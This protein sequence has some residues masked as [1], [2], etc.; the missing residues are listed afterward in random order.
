MLLP[1]CVHNCFAEGN[2]PNL[3]DKIGYFPVIGSVV[4]VIRVVCGIDKLINALV[5]KII[6]SCTK[7]DA[8]NYFAEMAYLDRNEGLLNVLRGCVEVVPFFGGACTC[9]YDTYYR[10]FNGELEFCDL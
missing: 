5:N 9:V 8:S 2:E 1:A 3:A 4:A 6:S 7:G 10:E